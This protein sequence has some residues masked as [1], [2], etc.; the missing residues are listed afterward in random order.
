MSNHTYT[1]Q[2]PERGY[3]IVPTPHSKT[4]Q[5]RA[6]DRDALEELIGT[7]ELYGTDGV[8]LEKL[9]LS[10]FNRIAA[11]LEPAPLS[12]ADVISALEDAGDET[13]LDVIQIFEGQNEYD[14]YHYIELDKPT[15][16][17]YFAAETLNFMGIDP[18]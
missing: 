12:V 10:E 8:D 14:F 9:S 4:V 17:R 3:D 11:A 13:D 18:E 6:E 15:L 7:L 1:F 16:V 5:V 2:T